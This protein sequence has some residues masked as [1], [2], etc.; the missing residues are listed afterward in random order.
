MIEI[1]IV[2]GGKQQQVTASSKT[3]RGGRENKDRNLRTHILLKRPR[4][5]VTPIFIH[6]QLLIDTKSPI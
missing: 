2:R 6:L 3:H 1:V 5:E 4:K